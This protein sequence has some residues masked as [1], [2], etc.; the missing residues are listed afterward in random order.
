MERSPNS[1]QAAGVDSAFSLTAIASAAQASIDR[2]SASDRT[3]PL[4]GEGGKDRNRRLSP[5][6]VRP[7]EGPLTEPRAGV[8]PTRRELV[9]MPHTGHCS[10]LVGA[11]GRKRTAIHSE[12][13]CL[14]DD[15]VGAG[16]E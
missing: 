9:L 2:R 16:E 7:D 6:P 4:R 1:G 14:F 15:L 8:Q 11:V 10:E 5:I 13:S 12:G 3:S